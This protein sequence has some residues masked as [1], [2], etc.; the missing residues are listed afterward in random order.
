MLKH[1]E[2]RPHGER[3]SIGFT[4]PRFFFYLK[5]LNFKPHLL[6][7]STTSG[8]GMSLASPFLGIKT[9]NLNIKH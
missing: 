8:I 7:L 3:G 9:R 4:V 5:N 6:F 1:C 2:V